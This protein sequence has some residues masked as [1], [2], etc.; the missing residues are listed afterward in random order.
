MS[1]LPLLMHDEAMIVT[2]INLARRRKVHGEVKSGRDARHVAGVTLGDGSEDQ[3][4][5]AMVASSGW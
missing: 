1:H 5:S 3:A 2:P 4:H